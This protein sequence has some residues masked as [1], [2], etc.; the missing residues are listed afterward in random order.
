[1]IRWF[2]INPGKTWVDLD[3]ELKKH[4]KEFGTYVRLVPNGP[5]QFS[6]G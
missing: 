3:R 4:Y 5:G 1:M 6:L 2:R